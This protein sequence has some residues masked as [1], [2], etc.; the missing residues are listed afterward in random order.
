MTEKFFITSLLAELHA[1][2]E[3]ERNDIERDFREHFQNGRAE[4]KTEGDI[5]KALGNPIDIAK[6][7]LDLY[8]NEAALQKTAT[9]ETNDQRAFSN[10]KVTVETGS[11]YVTPSPDDLPHAHVVGGNEHTVFTMDVIDNTLVIQL[12]E[13]RSLLRRFFLSKKIEVYVQLPK[14]QYEQVV[15]TCDDSSIQA[16]HIEATTF[17]AYSDNGSIQLN[18]CHATVVNTKTDNGSIH[19]EDCRAKSIEATSDNGSILLKQLHA[20][21]IVIRSDNGKIQLK[22]IQSETITTHSDNGLTRF[23]HVTANK[24]HAK[25]DNGKIEMNHVE[26]SIEA[27]NDNG[28]INCLVPTLQHKFHLETINGSIQLLTKEMPT[29]A[30]IRAFHG[31]GSSKIFNQRRQESIFGDG[32]FIVSLQTSNGSITVDTQ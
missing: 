12:L 22:N 26:G 23:T 15:L 21:S 9:S 29:N 7:L 31:N 13:N 1:L 32:H 5:S 25:S 20:T 2:S 14:K 11:L 28:G 27:H 10:V 18:D 19:L 30:T 3:E 24:I 17:K 6:E 4:G 16:E 8:S